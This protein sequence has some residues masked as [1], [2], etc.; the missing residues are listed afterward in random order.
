MW[1]RKPGLVP[2]ECIMEI[3]LRFPP[4]FSPDFVFEEI[5]KLVEKYKN[6]NQK[7]NIDI[8]LNDFC[9]AFESEKD[10][11]LVKSLTWA[12]RKV[13]LKPAFLVRKTGT[14][15]MNV[16][17]QFLKVPIVAYGPGDSKLDHSPNEHIK[18]N[19]YLTSIQ[20]YKYAI[21]KLS[22]LHSKSDK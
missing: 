12:I 11:L 10:S 13:T 7:V 19:E 1:R 9:P 4:P 18:I 16:L 3:D 17:G 20:V 5:K 8:N 2:D 6:E 21:I 14:A 22:E 15:D